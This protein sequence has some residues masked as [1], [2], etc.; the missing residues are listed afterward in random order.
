MDVAEEIEILRHAQVRHGPHSV[1]AGTSA[2]L[3]G[4]AGDS[5][6]LLVEMASA[7]ASQ[8]GVKVRMVPHGEEETAIFYDAD[9]KLL[10]VDTRRSGPDGTPK[11]V[12]A[13][14]LALRSDERLRLRVFV[15]KSVLEV[16]A[17]KRQAVARRIYPS[18]SDSIG[19]SL[20]ASG[21]DAQLHALKAW[22][23]SPSNPH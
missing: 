12:E 19:V 15:D 16:F 4:V 10:K 11:A 7:G 1:R 6:E 22:K 17:N 9:E 13:G 14:P 20:F 5:L 21:G 3:E 8:Y 2:A 18:R 23:L